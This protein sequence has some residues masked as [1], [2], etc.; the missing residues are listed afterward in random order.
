MGRR[1]R[2]RRAIVDEGITIPETDEI[3]FD[4]DHDRARGYYVSPQGIVVVGR[5]PYAAEDPW[6]SVEGV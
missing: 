6:R 1:A 2:I 3:G 4:R 5:A